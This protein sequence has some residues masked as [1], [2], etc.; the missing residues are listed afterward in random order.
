[1]RREGELCEPFVCFWTQRHSEKMAKRVSVHMP[2]SQFSWMPLDSFF[3]LTSICAV[4]TAPSR[5][6]VT[7][8]DAPPQDL[9]LLLPPAADRPAPAES[10]GAH[11][12]KLAFLSSKFP[13]SQTPVDKIKVAF[14]LP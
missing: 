7:V 14:L 2:D 13:S 9:K 6:L 10:K 12:R 8:A 4:G 3:V 5:E 1:M 11:F